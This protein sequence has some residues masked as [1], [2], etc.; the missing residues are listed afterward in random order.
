MHFHSTES[1]KVR[2]PAAPHMD[3]NTGQIDL[4][5]AAIAGGYVLGALLL[6]TLGAWLI[7]L[8]IAWYVRVVGACI[9]LASVIYGSTTSVIILLG[10]FDYRR[11]VAEWHKASLEDYRRAG[12]ETY[13]AQRDTQ[14]RANEFGDVLLAALSV[15][16]RIKAK[17]EQP[18]SV[19]QL[20]GPV[21]VKNHR[22]GDL[23]KPKA[24][25]M[26]KAFGELGIVTGRV[27]GFAGDWQP[28][29]ADELIDLVVKKWNR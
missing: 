26:S 12:G 1:I 14:L 24:E 18:Y 27:E 21:F 13:E 28:K 2:R 25:A 6:A 7:T 4:T 3:L 10:W 17:E 11:R 15:Y 16:L 23:T 29:T 9:V 20:A 22:V 8:D 5:Q 19:R